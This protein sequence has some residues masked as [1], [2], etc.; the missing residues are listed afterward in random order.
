MLWARWVCG[1]SC[2]SSAQ[3]LI[4]FSKQTHK[5]SCESLRAVHSKKLYSKT[6]AAQGHCG[7]FLLLRK[8]MSVS[9]SWSQEA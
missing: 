3:S 7:G 2:A 5:N 6:S 9:T 8:G 4:S 1:S